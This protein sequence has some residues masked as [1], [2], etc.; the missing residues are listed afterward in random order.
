MKKYVYTV[1]DK[2]TDE[3]LAYGDSATCTKAL[4]LSPKNGYNSFHSLVKRAN[5][6]EKYHTNYEVVIEIVDGDKTA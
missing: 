3:V 2:R 6:P 1:Y 5:N 4:K